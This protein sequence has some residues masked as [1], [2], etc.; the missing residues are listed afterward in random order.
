MNKP[1]KNG[2]GSKLGNNGLAELEEQMEQSRLQVVDL[3]LKARYWKAQYEIRHY[4]LLGEGLQDEYDKFIESQKVKNEELRQKMIEQIE[5]TRQ[6]MVEKGEI[7]DN[8]TPVEPE[9]DENSL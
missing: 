7:P 1:R 8:I 2:I 3:E 9:T 6:E 5:K 4:T